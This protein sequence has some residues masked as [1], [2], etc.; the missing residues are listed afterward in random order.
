[1]QIEFKLMYFLCRMICTTGMLICLIILTSQ[2]VYSKVITINTTGGSDSKCCV[3]GRCPCSSLSTALHGVTSNTVINITSQSVTLHS[4]VKMGSGHLNNITITS[5]DATVMCNNTGSVQCGWC[6]NVT[7]KGITWDKCGFGSITEIIPGIQFNTTAN[8]TILN[9]TFKNSESVAVSLPGVYENV[10]I[11]CCKFVSNKKVEVPDPYKPNFGGLYIDSLSV[12]YTV[13]LII[14][15]CSFIDN[16]FGFY[17]KESNARIWNINISQTDFVNNTQV[18]VMY[19]VGNLSVLLV[20]SELFVYNNNHIFDVTIDY[21]DMGVEIQVLFSNFSSNNGNIDVLLQNGGLITINNSIFI[22]NTVMDTPI[23]RIKCGTELQTLNGI[24]L[25]INNVHIVNN[26]IVWTETSTLDPAPGLVSFQSKCM[27]IASVTQARAISNVYSHQ[28]GGVFHIRSPEHCDVY[29]VDCIF[30]NNTGIHGAAIYTEVIHTDKGYNFH[31]KVT[32]VSSVFDKNVADESVF[33]IDT[34]SESDMQSKPRVF[35]GNSSFTNNLGVCLFLQRCSVFL[36]GNLLFKNNT[37]ENGGALYIDVASVVYMLGVIHFIDNSAVLH[38]GA[39][40][41]DLNL[42]CRVNQT[43][44]YPTDAEVSFISTMP[45]YGGN[46]LYFSVSKYCNINTNYKDYNSLMYMPYQFNYS[47]FINGTFIKISLDYHYT[48]LNITHFPVVTSPYRLN[49]YGHSV[50]YVEDIYF[51]KHNIVGVPVTFNGVLLDYFDKPTDTTEFIVQCIECY[52]SYTLQSSQ[53]LVDNASPIEVNMFGNEVTSSINVTLSLLSRVNNYY[54]QIKVT[55]VIEFVPCYDQP[56]YDYNTASKGCVC[57]HHDVV[58]CYEDYNEIKRGYWF[59]TVNGKATTS[60]C[61]SEYCRFVNRKKT[62]EGYF[63]LPNGVDIQCEHHRSGPACGKCSP[64]YTLVYDSPD[65]ISEDHCSAGMTVL[66]V[67]LTCL[68]WI[69]MV[70]GVFC[71]MYFNF[72]LSSGYLY[73]LIYYYSMVAILLSNNPY[74]SSG[75]AQFINILSGIAQLNPQF[76]GKLCLTRRMNGIDQLFI[77]YSHACAVSILLYGF[78]VAAKSSRRVAELISR[79]IIRVFCLLLLLAY[80]SLA[81]TSLQLLRP[82]KFTDIHELYTY[83]SPNKKYFQGRH[84]A[85]GSVA[86]TCELVIGIGLPLLLLLEPFLKRKVNFIRFK[87]ILDQ[88]Q[89]CYKGKYSWFAS[90]YLICRQVIM[91]IVLL[92]NS[93]YDSM[94]FYLLLTCVVIAT[95][96]MWLQPYKNKF[97]NIFDGLLLQLMLV[98]VIVSSF[99]FLQ[100]A[101]TELALVLVIFPLIVICIA[102]IIKK[103]LHY[104]RYQYF[105]INDGSDD[106]DDDDTLR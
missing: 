57:Y 87:P 3:K 93:N 30:S 55:L 102:A 97:L 64:G 51:I 23:V 42:G 54:H 74:I 2:H 52:N 103:S 56:G 39:I 19:P 101:T 73:G 9:C 60:L 78:V 25:L 1:M 4:N 105:A 100:F 33:Y 24:G 38:G 59:G 21:S 22:D 70:V 47:Q 28:K 63:E 79:C 92:G 67:L 106:D 31:F 10:T 81:S 32:I 98:A 62:R 14:H 49:L 34:P 15:G 94:L 35:I 50:N 44:F 71:L 61:S 66:V 7:I 45:G 88:F 20:L 89:G 11:E 48:E 69:V 41:V 17:L 76:L 13:N 65:C 77:H 96:H 58:E 36:S 5:C 16:G 29:F 90:Y 85:Y 84:V 8:I 53:V 6:N 75:A 82:L 86:I 68:Y 26:N 95:V 46:S 104:K 72:Q 83:S 18:S 40:Y 99:D 12:D 80:T 27:L 43:T 37:A 91:F